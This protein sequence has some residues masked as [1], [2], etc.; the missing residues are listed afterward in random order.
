VRQEIATGST[1]APD[2]KDGKAKEKADK[3]PN[4][5]NLAWAKDQHAALVT[6]VRA[7]NC[8]RASSIALS[9]SNRTPAYY[10]QNVETDR[11]VKECIAYIN[12][13]REKDAEMRASRAKKSRLENAEPSAPKR[14]ADQ[15]ARATTETQ[16]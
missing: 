4:D 16:K 14:A 5:P 3:A 8:G 15:P 9:I 10:A 11:S 1:T 6:A 2:A 12:R 13:E 7:N